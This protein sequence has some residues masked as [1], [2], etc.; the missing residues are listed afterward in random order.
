ML[1]NHAWPWL[2]LRKWSKALMLA[3]TWKLNL[4]RKFTRQLRGSPLP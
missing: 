2:I 3:K 4:L 1:W